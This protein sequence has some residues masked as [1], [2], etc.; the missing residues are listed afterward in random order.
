LSQFSLNYSRS[1]RSIRVN[2]RL[3]GRVGFI[4]IFGE[5]VIIVIIVF[6]FGLFPFSFI[7]VSV[8]LAF[9]PVAFSGFVFVALG[10][11]VVTF[12]LIGV[13]DFSRHL[14]NDIGKILVEKYG[15]LVTA[16]LGVF[17]HCR[18]LLY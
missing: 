5:V 7:G 4:L 15:A 9:S 11:F 18:G 6:L 10:V 2:H 8:F 16:I 12:A 1:R 13:Q 17:G 14:V 3:R